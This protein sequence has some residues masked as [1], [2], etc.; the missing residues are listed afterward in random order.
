S[1]MVYGPFSLAGATQAGLTLNMDLNSEFGVDYLAFMASIDNNHFHGTG[2]S[3]TTLG[4]FAEETL[5]LSPIPVIG[6]L[7]GQPN[8]WIGIV[9]QSDDINNLS[10]GAAVDDVLV[11]MCPSGTCGPLAP[12]APVSGLTAR[13]A[14]WTRP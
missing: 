10:L 11:R 12:T 4:S 3:G 13:S 14:T 1:W 2:Y 8:V 6:D 9:F 7:R 5:D